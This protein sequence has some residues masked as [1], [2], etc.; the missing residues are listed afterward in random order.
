MSRNSTTHVDYGVL[1][2]EK[3]NLRTMR[4]DTNTLISGKYNEVKA[5]FSSTNSK[6]AEELYEVADKLYSI[7]AILNNMINQ[8]IY[9]LDYAKAIFQNADTEMT[10]DIEGEG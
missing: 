10:T 7:N 5:V 1:D 6:A 8:T 2:A 4:T 9:T 3:Q